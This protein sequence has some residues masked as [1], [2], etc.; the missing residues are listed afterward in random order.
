MKT[1][2]ALIVFFTLFLFVNLL[3]AQ[4]FIKKADSAG[5]GIF[6]LKEAGAIVTSEKGEVKIEDMLPGEIRPKGYE[7]IDLKKGDKIL[8]FNAERVK[9]VKELQDKYE[10][11]KVGDEVKLGIQRD[12][13]MFIASFAKIDPEKLPKERKLV[14]RT[15]EPGAEGQEGEGNVIRQEIKIDDDDKTKPLVGAGLILKETDDAVKISY[16]LP[17]MKDALGDVDV[18]EADVV[19]ELNGNSVPNIKIFN[20]KYEKIQTG[21][22]ITLKMKR[23]DKVFTVKF[24]KPEEKSRIIIQK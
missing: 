3:Q 11:L 7:D 17:N 10:A 8:M 16:V 14:I 13:E 22:E 19:V 4:V 20:D 1:K 9:S 2:N 18:Q 6:I 23:K 5:E 24:K 15:A 12:T 21:D